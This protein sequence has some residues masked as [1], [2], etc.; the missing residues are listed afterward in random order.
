[1]LENVLEYIDMIV[2]Y[3]VCYGSI[4][5]DSISISLSL[6]KIQSIYSYISAPEARCNVRSEDVVNLHKIHVL[7]SPTS[8]TLAIPRRFPTACLHA[9]HLAVADRDP[10]TGPPPPVVGAISIKFHC[11]RHGR[12]GVVGAAQGTGG[13]IPAGSSFAAAAAA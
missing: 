11:R 5:L 2:L 13:P 10:R 12:C 4:G 6:L 3:P 7:P 8:S 1:M 9:M